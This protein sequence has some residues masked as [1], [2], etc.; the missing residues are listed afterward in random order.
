[1]IATGAFVPQAQQC[2]TGPGGLL[3]ADAHRHGAHTTRLAHQQETVADELAGQRTE[4]TKMDP[5][6]YQEI[7]VVD[8]YLYKKRRARRTDYRPP[9]IALGDARAVATE[10]ALR[11]LDKE[12]LE[13]LIDVHDEIFQPHRSIHENIAHSQKRVASLI[14]NVAIRNERLTRWMMFFTIAVVIIGLPTFVNDGVIPLWKWLSAFL[15]F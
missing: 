3:T 6:E 12:P 4:E 11:D 14:A 10:E 13:L 7:R 1:M 2:G 8:G 5:N 9:S 15:G